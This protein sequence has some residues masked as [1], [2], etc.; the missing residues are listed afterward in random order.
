LHKKIFAYGLE[1]PEVEGF[2]PL[3]LVSARSMLDADIIVVEPSLSAFTTH[4]SYQGLS[5]MEER[6]S[7][8]YRETKLRWAA[9]LG[10]ALKAGRTVF[11]FLTKPENCYFYTG[12]T[13]NVG[14]PGKPRLQSML[15]RCSS[16]D[17]LPL[18]L[19]EMSIADGNV[20]GTTK[21]GAEFLADYWRDFEQYSKYRCYFK[22]I[23]G[24]TTLLTTKGGEHAVAAKLGIGA[25]S[26]I[27]LPEL[28]WD[29]LSQDV[30]ESEP[31]DN[32]GNYHW[33]A[34]YVKFTLRLRDILLGMDRRL[35]ST[36][37]RT[38]SP[39]WAAASGYRLDTESA[40]EGE[41]LNVTAKIENLRTQHAELEIKL[42]REGSLRALLY[43]TGPR[44]EAAVRDALGILGF[45]VEHFADDQSE[46]D[47]IFV[48]SEGRFIGEVEGRDN[49]AVDV[50]KASQLHRNISEDFAKDDVEE[51]AIGVLF[52]NP[53][54]L[55]P[56]EEREDAFTRKVLTF[57]ETV[58]LA[59]VRTP[60]LFIVARH[61]RNTGD[62]AFAERCRMAIA[63]GRGSVVQFPATEVLES[64]E[65][66]EMSEDQG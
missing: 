32:Q 49:K 43:E 12:Q 45:R 55:R 51:M 29:H 27:V 15:Q 35:R 53:F 3:S 9:Q 60:D 26:L 6:S 11:F 22:S 58:G 8:T 40:T 37:E 65:V 24:S 19:S 46:F 4:G 5:K 59:L 14:T 25:G 28:T 1:L 31:C 66:R 52:G 38:E 10:A 56:P 63:A 23:G 21:E 39:A 34:D 16:Y 50:K 33:P 64:V 36:E 61:V 13:Q 44:L 48:S 2:E 47:A 20:F 42:E 62:I 18:G 54:R 41:M 57:A 7:S 30:T 17:F